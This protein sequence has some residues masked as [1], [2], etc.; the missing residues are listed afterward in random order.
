MVPVH[1]ITKKIKLQFQK[2]LY[3]W[4]HDHPRVM[5]WKGEKDPY[6]IWISEIIL[7]QTRVDQG[8]AY[9]HRFIKAFPTIRHLAKA[10][11]QKVLKLWE[12]LGYYTRARNLHH[13]AQ[14][15]V[16]SLNGKFPHTFDEIKKLKGIGDY[17]AAA[18]ASF[19]YQLPHAV[20]DGNVHRI[21]S[22]YIGVSRAIQTTADKKYVQSLADLLLDEHLPDRYNQAVMDFGAMCCTPKLPQCTICPLS[23]SCYAFMN[24]EVESLPPPKK[25]IQKK[26]RYFHYFIFKDQHDR[27]LIQK[28]KPGDVWADLFEFPLVESDSTEFPSSIYLKE[29]FPYKI[30]A[31]RADLALSQVLS[32]QIIKA[33]FYFYSVHDIGNDQMHSTSK[34]LSRLPMPG[35]IAKNRSSI[36]KILRSKRA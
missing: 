11:L 24:Q 28:R 1:K 20:L 2:G 21:I 5:P 26:T 22:R 35:I 25:T 29:V 4:S 7:Q 30:D 9:Y 23:T 18:I 12:G 14:Y 27:F 17:T 32:H 13:T 6:K 36:I 34:V 16:Q 8:L 10:P 31:Q 33:Q 3:Q 15:I 19:A